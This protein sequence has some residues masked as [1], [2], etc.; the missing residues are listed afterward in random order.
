VRREREVFATLIDAKQRL[1]LPAQWE[2]PARN[3]ALAAAGGSHPSHGTPLL[4]LLLLLLLD[5]TG[6]VASA[7]PGATFP[8]PNTVPLPLVWRLHPLVQAPLRAL[9]PGSTCTSRT[10]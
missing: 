3:L 1:V 4:L 7:A 8:A 10:R 2:E 5:T 9:T 6:D